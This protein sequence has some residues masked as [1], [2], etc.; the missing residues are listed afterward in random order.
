MMN[1]DSRL[2][3]QASAFLKMGKIEID[4]YLKRQAR[5]TKQKREVEVAFARSTLQVAP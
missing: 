4:R 2:R 5:D 3:P 1:Q